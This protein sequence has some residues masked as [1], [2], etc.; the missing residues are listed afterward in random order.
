MS[1]C[2]SNSPHFFLFLVLNGQSERVCHPSREII[3]LINRLAHRIVINHHNPA[4][5]TPALLWTL[6]CTW[7]GE[8][9]PLIFFMNWFRLQSHPERLHSELFAPHTHR[10]NIT[11]D[12]LIETVNDEL[13]HWRSSRSTFLSGSARVERT[14]QNCWFS[15]K[16]KDRKLNFVMNFRFNLAF[17]SYLGFVIGIWCYFTQLY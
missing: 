7:S 4:I 9:R 5:Y 15:K 6:Q 16:V 13:T 8:R 11:T 10:S 17:L 14:R 12:S 3:T 2:G 1:S